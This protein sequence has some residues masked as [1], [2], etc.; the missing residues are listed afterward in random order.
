VASA[1]SHARL[2]RLWSDPR[3]G[4]PDYVRLEQLLH[5]LFATADPLL[6]VWAKTAKTC[7]HLNIPLCEMAFGSDF[8]ALGAA[9]RSPMAFSDPAGSAAGLLTEPAG[10]GLV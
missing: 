9:R 5:T 10:I 8:A 6:V 3:L 1:Q 7:P 4:G 2:D